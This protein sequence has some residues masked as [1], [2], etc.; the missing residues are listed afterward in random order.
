[1]LRTDESTPSI[2]KWLKDQGLTADG[3]YESFVERY[4]AIAHS[5]GRDVAG[6]E[7]IYKHFGTKLD[8]STI[9]HQWLP[10]STISTEATKNGATETEH[11]HGCADFEWLTGLSDDGLCLSRLRMSSGTERHICFCLCRIPLPVVDGRRVV[12][13]RPRHH[14]ADHVQAGALRG[15]HRG[16]VQHPDDGRRRRAVG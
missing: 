6:W 9:I 8:K 13:G 10:G 15:D 12:P 7:E 4:Q 16:G 2:A 1:M 11:P 5:K 14:L 3:G